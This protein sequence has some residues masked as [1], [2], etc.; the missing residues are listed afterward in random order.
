METPSNPSE[1]FLALS[2]Q[3]QS[4]T[5]VSRIVALWEP[6]ETVLIHLGAL[7]VI[8]AIF[9]G[10]SLYVYFCF[11][12]QC[13]KTAE[14]NVKSGETAVKAAEV[15]YVWVQL[16][17]DEES[18]PGGRLVRTIVSEGGKCPTV[19]EDGRTIKMRQRPAPARAA[20][21]VLL[22]ETELRADSLAQ[23][24]NR[25]L[26]TRPAEPNDIV[27]I[28]DTGCRMT[29]YNQK[30][31]CL[32]SNDWPFK[33]IAASAV[34]Q[35]SARSFVLHLGDFHYREHPCADSSPTCGGSPY[36]DNWETWETEFFEPA[37]P[38]LRVAPWVIMRGN[39]EDCDRAGAGWLFFFA[40]PGQKKTDTACDSEPRS[41]N[42]DIGTTEERRPRI[43]RVMDTSDE[44]NPYQIEKRC[45]QYAEAAKALDPKAQKRAAPEYWLAMHQPLW[46]RNMDGWQG[47]PER[48]PKTEGEESEMSACAETGSAITAIRDIFEARR[49]ERFARV[50]LAGDTHAFQFFWP[51]EDV[52][53]IQIVA[54][55]G[56]TALDE[57][58]GI[59]P[60]GTKRPFKRKE[61]DRDNRDVL[62]D[63]DITS[64]GVKGSS[65]TLMQHGFTVLHRDRLIWTAIQF[66]RGGGTLLACRFSE[67]LSPTEPDNTPRCEPPPP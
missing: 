2:L 29:Y 6:V 17:P 46:L 43:L 64:F 37:D 40:L 19:Q 1:R 35:I 60:L 49:K 5:G 20:F 22:C 36:G 12:A 51:N 55:N 56:G 39:H 32:D 15:N 65:R 4:S 48:S 61:G 13:V 45:A 10:L 28:G 3:R 38:L 27:V 67:A 9:A 8:A 44:K 58:Y 30:Q 53:P 42:I 57:L 24:G 18:T 25:T 52:T 34:R 54:G 66:D 63:R 47:D 26:P 23:L 31:S 14:P 16:M 33:K 62:S 21:P 59:L 7:V 50:T 41:Y 11:A